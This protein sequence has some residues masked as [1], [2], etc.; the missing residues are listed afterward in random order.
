MSGV[1]FLGYELL[2]ADRTGTMVLAGAALT[3][4][5]AYLLWVDFAAPLLGIRKAKN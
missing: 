5:G 1:Y 3:F 2:S 4:F